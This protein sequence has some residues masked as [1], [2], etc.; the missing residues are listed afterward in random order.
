MS[1]KEGG[2]FFRNAWIAGVKKHYPG[3]PK[4]SYIAPWETMPEWE[5]EI[6]TEIYQQVSKLVKA[7]IQIGNAHLLNRE[8]GGRVIRIAWIGQVYK[9]MSQPKPAY[10]CAWEEMSSWEQETD[11]DIFEAIQERVGQVIK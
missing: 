1:E 10:V 6:V 5:K 2:Q 4:P 11:M 7:G 3:T 8:Q 9:H